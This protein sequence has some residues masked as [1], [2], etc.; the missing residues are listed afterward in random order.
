MRGV[1]RVTEKVTA[2]LAEKRFKDFFTDGLGLAPGCRPA[3]RVPLRLKVLGVDFIDGARGLAV[4]FQ[5]GGGVLRW[6]IGFHILIFS[7]R[8]IP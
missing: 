2:R 4:E 3:E 8:D 6:L 1:G 7:L 5:R